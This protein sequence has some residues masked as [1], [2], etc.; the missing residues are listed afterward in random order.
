[1]AL[2]L[3]GALIFI[4]IGICLGALIVALPWTVAPFSQPFVKLAKTI[5]PLLLPLATVAIVGTIKLPPIWQV[6]IGAAVVLIAV[7]L[8][9]VPEAEKSGVELQAGRPLLTKATLH[10]IA[11]LLLG[12]AVIV[13]AM[14][15]V[16]LTAR[17]FD[18][19]GGFAATVLL[20]AL[21]IWVAA[22]GLRL[23]SYATSW[24]RAAV[25]LFLALAGVRLAIAAGILPGDAWLSENVPWLLPVLAG[26]AAVLLLF[27]AALNVLVAIRE[28]RSQP[29]GKEAQGALGVLL[30]IR[31]GGLPPG[32]ISWAGGMGVS[33]ALVAAAVLLVSTGYGLWV[34]NQPGSDLV[35]ENG[36]RVRPELPTTPPGQVVDDLRLAKSYAPILAFTDDERWPPIDVDSYLEDAILKGPAGTVPHHTSLDRLPRSCPGLAPLPCYQLTIDC[37]DGHGRC[38][39]KTEF[40]P[41]GFYRDGA[42]YFRVVRKDEATPAGTPNVFVDRGRFRDSLSILIQYWYF[43]RYDEWEARAFAGLLT[44]RHEG[45]WEA[46]TIGLSREKPLFVA[47]SAH[48]AGSWRPWGDV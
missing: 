17:Y 4:A 5:R 6:L 13:P 46:V 35:A 24:L 10:A 31:D 12:C 8:I 30:G 1:V 25:A 38:G 36:D 42:V 22:F 48:C 29:A 20:L 39:K 32:L 9:L 19:I 34:T 47:Y 43:Y 26:T 18:S 23:L 28:R 15:M 37:P 16:P 14:A 3:G 27:E 11:I 44:Q 7:R 45:D 21:A 2:P 33:T 40:E 41:G